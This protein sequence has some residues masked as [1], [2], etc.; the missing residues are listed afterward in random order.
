[1]RAA[2]HKNG[3]PKEESRDA[4]VGISEVSGISQNY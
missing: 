4:C 3:V 2:E 1:M